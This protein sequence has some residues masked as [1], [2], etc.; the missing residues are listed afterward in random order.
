MADLLDLSARIID[1]GV[2][3]Q[4]VN[5]VTNELSELADDLAIVESF[6]HSVAVRTDEGV[7]AFDA[8]GVHTG[9]AVVA[10]LRGWTAQ[11]V[12]HL[13]YTH[14]HAD[15]VGGSSFFA[16]A[17]E[18][19]GHQRAT[20]I[21]HQNVQPRLDRYAL[22]NNWNL[23][24][25]ARQFGGVPGELNLSIGDT[26][27]GTT[28]AANPAARRFLP[29]GTMA[30][31]HSVGDL[32]TWSIGDQ[33]IELHHARGETDDHLWAWF[34]ERRW[35]MTGDFVIWNFPNAGNPQKVQRYPV[36]WAAA[37]RAMIAKRPELL[38]PAHGLPIAGEQRIARVLDDI[39]TALE[40]L[41]DEV[42]A[43][44]NAGET[45]DA[46]VHTVR[47]PAD[48]LAKPYLRPFY[49]EPEFVVRNVWRRFGGWWDGAASRLKPSPDAQLAGVLAELAGGADAVVRRAEQAASDGDLRLACHLADIAGWASPDD[50]AVHGA[51]A[52]I[53][54]QRRTAESSLMS[55]GI[56]AAAAR[57]SQIVVENDS[58]VTRDPT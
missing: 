51:R 18:R 52:A 50:A 53:Y 26:A 38:V 13:V 28:V 31:D 12:S 20:V 16:A 39:A 37:L 22:T 11:P 57:E 44:M 46:I 30:P 24:I 4:P 17:A 49:D 35:V 8:S 32:S 15:H 33:T 54:L 2:A 1:S 41:V 21:G 10:A 48:T 27:E 19:D 9:A 6:S 47:V 40:N 29:V 14:G 23:I 3:D 43:M 42:L 55:K 25:N 58:S 36:E 56:F 34:P 5:R 45:L 7:V